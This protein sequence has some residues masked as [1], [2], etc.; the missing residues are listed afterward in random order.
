MLFVAGVCKAGL[1]DLKAVPRLEGDA[2]VLRPSRDEDVAKRASFGRRREIVRAMGSE[3]DV[4]EPMSHE[5][6]RQ[7]LTRRFGLGP[8]WVIA[9][10]EDEFLGLLRLAPIDVETTAATF[11]VAIF[12]QHRLGQGFGT[13]ATKLAVSYGFEELGLHRITLTV[14]AENQ[15]AV[16]A[17]RNAGFVVERRLEKTLHRDG[18]FYDDLVMSVSKPGFFGDNTAPSPSYG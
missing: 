1:M 11:A 16:L 9:D 14:L 13:E 17:Y 6:A 15:R 4:D 2:V 7:Q 8:H 18:R 10:S 5:D 12:D 3:L